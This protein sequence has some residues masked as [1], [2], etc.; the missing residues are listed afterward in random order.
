MPRLLFSAL[1]GLLFV[2]GCSSTPEPAATIGETGTTTTLPESEAAKPQPAGAGD[3]LTGK[4]ARL[5]LLSV[6][7]LPT[8]WASADTQ[9]EIEDSSKIQPAA[10]QKM[11]DE[12]DASSEDLEPSAEA[13]ATFSQGGPLGAQL[14]MKVAS[15]DEVQTDSVETIADALTKCSTFKSTEHGEISEIAMAALSFPNL[16]DQTL[17]I[18][19]RV[20]TQGFEG[21]ADV[22]L[23]A[24]GHNLVSFTTAGLQ[25]I[26]GAELEKIARRGMEKVAVAAKS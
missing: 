22:V 1:I 4:Q 16:G 23:V 5:A 14:E 12:L 9:P 6:A 7:D 19:M 25:P 18:R 13:K 20:K 2:T 15:F 26:A 17:A 8:G 3:E 24:V 21:V 11:F 10:C